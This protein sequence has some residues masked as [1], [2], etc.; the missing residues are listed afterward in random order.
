[1][2]KLKIVA[3]LKNKKEV[4]CEFIALTKVTDFPIL[5]CEYVHRTL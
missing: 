3:K 2:D 4:L 5:W 1:M